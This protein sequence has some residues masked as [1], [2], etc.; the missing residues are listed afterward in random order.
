MLAACVVLAVGCAVLGCGRKTRTVGGVSIEEVKVGSGATA[1][2]G[3]AVSV[4]YAGRLLDGTKF[5]SGQDTGTPIEFELGAGKVIKG[6]D[7]GIEGMRVGG[8]RKLTVPPE[9]AYGTLPSAPVPPNSTLVFDVELMA[10][11]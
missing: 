6:W 10:V 1:T 8:K 3:K 7:L 2:A 4:Q 11:K 9:Y 5:D